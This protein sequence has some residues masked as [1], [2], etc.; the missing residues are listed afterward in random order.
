MSEKVF[1]FTCCYIYAN[2]QIIYDH[3]LN[4]VIAKAEVD[5]IAESSLIMLCVIIL[6]KEVTMKQLKGKTIEHINQYLEDATLEHD[7][8][9]ELS[10][11][12]S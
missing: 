9:G 8:E 1:E 6:H 7:M 2:I 11:R 3:L 5:I 12:E 10:M 4:Q